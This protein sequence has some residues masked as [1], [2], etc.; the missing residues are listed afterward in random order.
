MPA[1][2]GH[3]LRQPFVP[4]PQLQPVRADVH[5]LD[6]QLDDARLLGG[7]ELAH[8]G[9]SAASASR[10]SSSVRPSQSGCA[11]R[12]VPTTISGGRSMPRSWSMT[13][14]SISAAGTRAT[15][16]APAPCFSTVWLT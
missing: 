15:G 14:A 13:A 3:H 4:E 9:S 16:Q 11:A 7:E 6:Q 5:A 12:H 10:T 8:S 1:D 2:L